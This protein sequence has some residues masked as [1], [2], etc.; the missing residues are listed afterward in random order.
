MSA[1]TSPGSL[2][3]VLGYRC[4]FRCSFCY[5]QRR[6]GAFLATAELASVLDDHPGLAP[7]FVTVMGGEA[8]LSR[9]LAEVVAGLRSRFPKAELSLTTNGSAS[10]E[11]YLDLAEAGLQN[12]TF[13]VPT[14]DAAL[15]PRVTGQVRQGLGEYL[16]KIDQLRERAR[17]TI[18]LN[19]YAHAG[20]ALEYY[21]YCKARGLRLTLCEDL[22]SASTATAQAIALPGLS[23]VHDDALRRIHQDVDGFQVW[24]YRHVLHFRDYDNLIVLPNGTTT[25]DFADV[26]A[27]RG[28]RNG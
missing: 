5:Q 8:T 7:R 18:R 24:Q 15:Y 1:P 21:R 3:V 11:A 13:S 19:A 17:C 4:N 10:A 23:V 25:A 26:L 14:L 9:G 28:A 12:L 22:V 2:R 20:N 27:Q 16:G 6:D